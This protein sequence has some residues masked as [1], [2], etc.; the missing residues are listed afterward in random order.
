MP[1]PQV[2][3]PSSDFW[4]S[5][6]KTSLESYLSEQW[7]RAE[8]ARLEQVDEK[9]SR[10]QRDYDGVPRVERRV[11]PWPGA[12][13]YV[14]Q[15][16][17]MFIDTFV[18]RTL[19][20]IFATRPLYILDF[21]PDDIRE[22]TQKYIN[23][24]ALVEWKHY[25]LCKG[26]LMRGAK[27]GTVVHK[28]TYVV[29]EEYDV[30]PSPDGGDASENLI[31]TYDGPRTELVPFEDFYIYPITANTLDEAEI[32]FHRIRMVEEVAVRR[33]ERAGWPM[34]EDEIRSL[35]VMPR[36]VK[37]E[38]E[39]SKAGV[40]DSQLR[41]MNLIECHLKWA[42]M[43]DGRYYKVIALLEPVK[44]VLF[45]VYYHPY[46]QNMP[47]FGDYRP[48][49]KED[50][51]FGD[52]W[53]NVLQQTQDEISGIH[54]DRRNA[55]Y[56]TNAPLFKRKRNAM[57]PNPSTTWYPGKV[58]DLENMDDFEIV[59]LKGGYNDMLAEENHGLM[60]AE[61]YVGLGALQQ[62]NASGMMGKRGIYN[63][64][65]TLAVISESNQRQDT[66]IK[67][68][69]EVMGEIAKK[70]FTLQSMYN[71]NDPMIDAYP[72]EQAEQIK[73]GL[74]L[75]GPDLLR[76]R[77]FEIKPSDAGANSEVA[78]ANTL[79]LAQVLNQY[80]SQVLQM[81]PTLI[82]MPPS[83]VQQIFMDTVRMQRWMA[84]RLMRVMGEY[85]A[86]SIIPD[87]ERTLTGGSP[88]GME[89][90]PPEATGG[91]PQGIQSGASGGPSAGTVGAPNQQMLA[92]LANLSLPNGT[93]AQ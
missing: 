91:G 93:G 6:Y 54:N 31:T 3:R 22:I 7:T 87:I 9:Y 32:L 55:S 75:I 49:P 8:M 28:T 69:R 56:I 77:Y 70:C 42:L 50:F 88:A 33:S 30:T 62:G 52:S 39:Q 82:N 61:R 66:N 68:V 12:S 44:G 51:F 21:L 90:L 19:N 16:A 11:V 26:L 53:V 5:E 65:G 64:A 83:P 48:L 37:R 25:N 43:N 81:A 34:T 58:W 17:R 78:K 73:R 72:P 57:V 35:C 59:P 40:T 24:K 29:E 76:S 79:Q 2:I 63:A 80:G 18:A 20:I 23:K 74:R 85:D 41:E 67:D 84:I 60:L 27:N 10:W 71:P 1:A 46:P 4:D 38:Q 45:D 13:N 86:E 89:G 36:D 47:I 92:Q 15:V 14:V